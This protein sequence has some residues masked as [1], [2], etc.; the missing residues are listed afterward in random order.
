[1][2]M[3][4]E[5]TAAVSKQF[6]RKVLVRQLRS[7]RLCAWRLVVGYPLSRF[8]NREIFCGSMTLE[9]PLIRTAL[10]SSPRRISSIF[11]VVVDDYLSVFRVVRIIGQKDPKW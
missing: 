4:E 5:Y 1:M 11:Y 8:Y 3:L 9:I 7:V 2:S 10:A 6:S